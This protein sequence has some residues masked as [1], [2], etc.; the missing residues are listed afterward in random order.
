[1]PK[2]IP[3]D[4]LIMDEDGSFRVL[5]SDFTNWPQK[6]KPDTNV[7]ASNGTCGNGMSCNSGTNVT[8]TN[9][10]SCE[11]TYNATCGTVLN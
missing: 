1:M 9:S 6:N 11:D 3:I 5:D 7:K 10:N 2:K 8:C 4:S